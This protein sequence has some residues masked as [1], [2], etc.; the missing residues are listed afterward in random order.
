[1]L[2]CLQWCS[3]SWPATLPHASIN[4]VPNVNMFVFQRG[5]V[6]NRSASSRTI[7]IAS[8]DVVR[9]AFHPA[10]AVQ[11]AAAFLILSTWFPWLIQG[12]HQ[13]QLLRHLHQRL[14]L[15]NSLASVTQHKTTTRKLRVL[16]SECVTR[17]A[18]PVCRPSLLHAS[19]HT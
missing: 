6:Q 18:R 2:L 9:L 10:P 4:V 7:N 19:V 13:L 11:A 5:V 8:L 3:D 14:N 16:S 12:Q 1:M 17:E 15:R